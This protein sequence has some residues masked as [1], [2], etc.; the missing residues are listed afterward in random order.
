MFNLLEGEASSTTGNGMNNYMLWIFVGILIVAV[1]VI[2]IINSRRYKKQQKDRE[3]QMSSIAVGDKIVTIGLIEGEVVEIG[4]GSYVLKTG[5]EVNASYVRIQSGAV[6][7]ILKPERENADFQ[8]NET[9]SEPAVFEEET[10][11]EE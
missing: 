8:T 3:E 1:V 7:Q 11:S 10:K 5:S 6:Y 4:D 2:W 9:V